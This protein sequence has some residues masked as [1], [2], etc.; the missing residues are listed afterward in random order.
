M[1]SEQMMRRKQVEE[2]AGLRRSKLY[3]LM[4]RSEFPRPVELPGT[5]AKRWLRS[6][7]EHWVRER[8]ADRDGGV[9]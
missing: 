5:K 3:A 6:E 4:A 2:M 7:I 8:I 9:A 1:K